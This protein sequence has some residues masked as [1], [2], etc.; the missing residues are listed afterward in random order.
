MV[1]TGQV[2]SVDR[3]GVRV[4]SGQGKWLEWTGQVL[5]CGVDRAGVRVWCGQGRWLEWTGQVLGC[6]VDRA[7]VRVWSG[8]GRCWGV[9]WTG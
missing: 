4:W 7:G 9:E 8:Q 3:A 2:A 1:W 6:G 5:G